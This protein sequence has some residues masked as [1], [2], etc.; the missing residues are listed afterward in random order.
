MNQSLHGHKGT[1]GG[2]GAAIEMDGDLAGHDGPIFPGA[3]FV[4]H[5]R[6]MTQVG[7]DDRLLA[8]VGNHHW[9]AGT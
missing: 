5:T 2:I 8:I 6:G 4:V 3:C 9:S 1:L 7:A